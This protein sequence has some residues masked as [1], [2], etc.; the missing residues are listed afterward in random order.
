M[1]RRTE[2]L[3]RAYFVVSVF[4]ILALVIAF[5]VIKISL[6]EGERMM[7]KNQN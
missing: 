6:I 4:A 2:L 1:N 3:G 5:R 7:E